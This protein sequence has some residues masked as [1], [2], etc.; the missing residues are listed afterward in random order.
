[1][2][3]GRTF[4]GILIVVVA[5]LALP[6]LSLSA[7]NRIQLVAKPP[8]LNG[9]TATT[10]AAPA[11]SPAPAATPAPAASPAP[12]TLPS[13]A[14]AA[15]AAP[16]AKTGSASPGASVSR[17]QAGATAVATSAAEAAGSSVAADPTLVAL[18]ALGASNLYFTYLTLGTVADGYVSGTYEPQVAVSVAN[19]SIFM[20][21]TA[22]NNLSKMLDSAS[23]AKEDKDVVAYMVKTYDVLINQAKALV[24]FISNQKDDGSAYQKHRGE[25]WKRIVDLFGIK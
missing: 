13:V 5:A 19:E 14:P 8:K 16:A 24:Q 2:Q 7:E 1:M 6:A 22:M 4:S 23:L 15:S 18:G 25:A 9:G 17:P 12:E 20:N 21:T 10:Q 3:Q 11:A